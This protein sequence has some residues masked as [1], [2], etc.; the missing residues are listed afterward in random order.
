[1]KTKTILGYDF[2]AVSV[3]TY[4]TDAKIVYVTVRCF[5]VVDPARELLHAARYT[6]HSLSNAQRKV[7]R[8][9]ELGLSRW[10]D[11]TFNGASIQFE[12]QG[13]VNRGDWYAAHLYNVDFNAQNLAVLNKLKPVLGEMRY[14]GDY[15]AALIKG[16]R[17]LRA[18]EVTYDREAQVWVEAAKPNSVCADLLTPANVVT[19]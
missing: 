1:M 7:R 15:L 19:Q 4:C 18:V 16:L 6:D 14:G 3:P 12:L 17:D 10:L 5:D 13:S 11:I 2:S 8:I 9:N